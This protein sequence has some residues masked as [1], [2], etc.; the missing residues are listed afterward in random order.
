ML[1]RR[2][3]VVAT[4]LGFVPTAMG[5]S[6]LALA[7]GQ[8]SKN[9]PEAE[10]SSAD[11]PDSTG[12]A[13][14]AP[15]SAATAAEPADKAEGQG[16]KVAAD[17]LFKQGRQ[18]MSEGNL[19]AACR[20]FED[21]QKA[22]PAVGTLLNLGL[23]YK[24]LGRFASAW[25]SYNSAAAAARDR[26]QV[27]REKV[28]RDEARKLEARLSYLVL[29]VEE[30]APEQSIVI[31]G[32]TPALK[33]QWG[34]LMPIDPGPHQISVSA[35]GYEPF[36]LSFEI[37]QRE[38]ELVIPALQKVEPPPP[39][40]KPVPPPPVEP[41]PNNVPLYV[42]A[43]ATAALAAGVA[44]TGVMYLSERSEYHD[45][46]KQRSPGAANAREKAQTLSTVN[47]LALGA[48]LIGAGVTAYLWFEPQSTDQGESPS[49][50]TDVDAAN[51]GLTLQLTPQVGTGFAGISLEGQL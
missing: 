34:Q 17:A 18:L 4:L 30:P 47:L 49:D 48:T 3:V 23:C 43:G 46:N 11:V 25:S 12:S 1:C 37:S 41:A 28:A 22:D 45:L 33:A 6:S 31:D 39:P 36:E 51:S 15:G 50:G 27:E 35:E 24:E 8:P 16:N 44:V 32:D 26:N 38:T 19:E 14:P 2:Y 42:A 10:P 29:R 9:E 21:S 7:Q 40:P 13:E 5:F 20:A